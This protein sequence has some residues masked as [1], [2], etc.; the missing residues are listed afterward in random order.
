MRTE[1][2]GGIAVI[3]KM[4]RIL[5]SLAESNALNASDISV[6]LGIPRTTVNRLLQTMVK[7]QMLTQS[8]QLGP[9]LVRWASQALNGSGI[10]EACTPALEHLVERFGETASV[11]IRTGAARLC[12]DRREGTE[13]VRHNIGVGD[14]MP[15]HVGSA[16]RILLAWLDPIERDQ[17][18]GESAEWSGVP[19][20]K[21]A[22]DWNLIRKVGWLTTAGERDPILASVSVPILGAKRVVLAALSISGPRMRFL[23]DRVEEMVA[24]LKREANAVGL[25]LQHVEPSTKRTTRGNRR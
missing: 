25:Q 17:L 12:L 3:G 8:Y 9:R 11:F 18:I 22:P 15:I 23:S 19:V 2:V 16:G 14:S 20:L 24:C 5:D 1:D 7:E 4:A 13:S 6:D 10:R 21:P